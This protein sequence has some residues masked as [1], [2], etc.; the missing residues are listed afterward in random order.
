MSSGKA[1]YSRQN[2]LVTEEFIQRSRFSCRDFALYFLPKE[3]QTSGPGVCVH[4]TIPRVIKIDLGKLG[5]EL[6]LLLLVQ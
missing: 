5:E 4:L 1:K 3:I 2:L 6:S